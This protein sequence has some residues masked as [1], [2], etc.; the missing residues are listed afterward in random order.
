VE[1]EDEMRI[2]CHVRVLVLPSLLLL[3]CG[4][5][6][7]QDG[8]TEKAEGGYTSAAKITRFIQVRGYWS[9]NGYTITAVKQGGPATR[10][11]NPDGKTVASMEPGDRI[12]EVEGIKIASQVDYAMAM[13][14]AKD[15][16]RIEMKVRDRNSGNVYTWYI[17]SKESPFA[18]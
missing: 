14:G 8:E 9:K 10:M 6:L 4:A 13:D 3:L 2:L 16:Q 17:G 11:E 18:K 15:P 12:V 7:A 5:T 1:K